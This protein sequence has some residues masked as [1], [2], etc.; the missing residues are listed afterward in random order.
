MS[1]IPQEAQAIVDRANQA[2]A[3]SGIPQEAQAIFDRANQTIE[4]GNV[5]ALLQEMR[6]Q[7]S[8]QENVTINRDVQHV[9]THTQVSRV[10]PFTGTPHRLN[11]EPQ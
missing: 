6:S 11:D 2:I 5:G 8:E 4:N 1:G 7:R 9:M 10:A 3:M